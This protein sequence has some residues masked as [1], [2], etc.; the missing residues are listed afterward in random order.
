VTKIG[1]EE[2]LDADMVVMLV[3]HRQF[4]EIPAS[5]VEG[6]VLVDTR[7]VWKR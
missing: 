3:D 5:R 4:K 1:I 2:G 7:G 6:K